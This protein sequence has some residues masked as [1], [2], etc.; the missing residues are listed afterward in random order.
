MLFYCQ[1]QFHNGLL[2]DDVFAATS[3]D[4]DVAD[5]FNRATGME[6]IGLPLVFFL[7]FGNK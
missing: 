5:L 3:I 2:R 1:I 4:D 7:L 6:D